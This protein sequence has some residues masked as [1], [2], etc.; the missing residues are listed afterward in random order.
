MIMHQYSLLFFGVLT[1]A[2]SAQSPQH[3]AERRGALHA[4]ARASAP[5]ARSPRRWLQDLW[6]VSRNDEA[7]NFLMD[8]ILFRQL[9]LTTTN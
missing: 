4:G 2:H 5:A 1:P 9:L 7:M 3:D 6:F 8:W